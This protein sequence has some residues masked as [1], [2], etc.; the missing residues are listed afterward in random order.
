MATRI[1]AVAIRWLRRFSLT[2]QPAST[3][4]GAIPSMPS[5]AKRSSAAPRKL[6]SPRSRIAHGLLSDRRFRIPQMGPLSS[7]LDAALDAG[8]LCVLTADHG[9]VVDYE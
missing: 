7:C 4:F 6:L 1:A 3:S 2:H 8:R 9:H 5:P